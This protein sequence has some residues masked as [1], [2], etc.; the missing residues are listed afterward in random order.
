ML[1]KNF[2]QTNVKIIDIELENSENMSQFF[3]LTDRVRNIQIRD[4]VVKF[5][6]YKHLLHS[7]F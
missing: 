1:R 3:S 4:N 5:I 2:K 7:C 6:N